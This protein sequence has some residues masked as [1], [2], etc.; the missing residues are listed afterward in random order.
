VTEPSAAIRLRA[1]DIAEEIARTRTRLSRSMAALDREYALRNLFV[2][3]LRTV[4][5]GGSHPSELVP[6]VRREAVPLALIGIG[7]VWIALRHRERNDLLRR[8]TG[9]LDLLR[10]LGGRVDTT[11][12]GPT[13]P[14]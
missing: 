9:A 14:P 4:R 5:S 2:H 10:D 3:A 7:A 11:S 6:S 1:S 13:S 8:L 12:K